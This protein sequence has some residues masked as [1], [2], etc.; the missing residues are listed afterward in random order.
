ML[1]R[2]PQ[3]FMT[4]RDHLLENP[5]LKY[6][7]NIFY[8]KDLHLNNAFEGVYLKLRI[9]ENRI[10][11]DEVVKTSA[12][13]DRQHPHQKG[14]GNEETTLQKLIKYLRA[15][16]ATSVLELGCGNG[17]LSIIYQIL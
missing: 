10:H 2:K 9:K 13:T 16:G 15:S 14:M 12:R 3:R 8:E 4:L 11:S 5:L 7:N 17:W 1:Y 6:Q